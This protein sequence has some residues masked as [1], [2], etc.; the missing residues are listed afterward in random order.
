MG[1]SFLTLLYMQV[2]YI[3]EMVKMRRE[4]FDESVQR[5]LDQACRN[6]EL[7]E[8]RKYLEADAEA[9]ERAAQMAKEN[10][11]AGNAHVT[12]DEIYQYTQSYSISSARG[13]NRFEW[14]MRI[15]PNVP[16]PII[17]TG[18]NIPQTAR[19]LR[20]ILNDRYVYQQA[21]LN[22]VIY[23]I[24][25]TASDKPL[26]DRVNFKQLDV[27]LKTE[28]SNNGITIPYH[29][30]VTDRMGALIYHC[31]DYVP[32]GNEILYSHTLFNY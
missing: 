11:A 31:S 10:E 27:E 9:T 25:R 18:K 19:T 22:E 4:Q 20:E 6:I 26:K 3:E 12:D 15:E 28:L 21:L 30:S 5:G 8:T 16:K 23:N 29:F 13:M 14:K 2:S 17:S 1:L 32:E 7:A 24:L